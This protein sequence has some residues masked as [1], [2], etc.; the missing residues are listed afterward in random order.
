MANQTL[1]PNAPVATDVNTKLPSGWD[2]TTFQNFKTANPNISWPTNYDTEK[3][4]GATN[5][6]SPVTP[7]ES[8]INSANLTPTTPMNVTQPTPATSMTG[9]GGVT[10]SNVKTFVQ[11]QSDNLKATE[12]PTQSFQDYLDGITSA[13][14]KSGTEANIYASGGVDTANSE[15]KD[16]NNQIIAEQVA[17]RRRLEA[18]DK[19]PNGML[20]SGLQAEKDRINRE[21]ISK[22]ADLAVIQMSKQGKYDSAKAIADRLVDAKMEEQKNKLD[23]LQ[24]T[25]ENN[26]SNFTLAEQRDF[27]ARQKVDERKYEEDKTNLKEIS[28]LSIKALENGA[29]V[30]IASQMR[31]ATKL[32]D[33]IVIGGQYLR[34]Q[35][36]II[37]NLTPGNS[38]LSN[39]FNSAVTGMPAGQMK[40]ATATFNSLVNSGDTA[41]AKDYLARVAVAGAPTDQQ[42][43][44]IGRKQAIDSLNEVQS[45]LEQAKNAGATTNI[46]TGNFNDVVNKLGVSNDPNLTYIG[47]RIA[48]V[49]QTYR[50]SM[51]GV[52]FSPAE[53]A[54]YEKVFPS[55]TN[56][57]KLNATKLAA[58]RDSLNSNNRTALSFYIGTSNYDKIFGESQTGNLPGSEKVSITPED[59]SLFDSIVGTKTEIPTNKEDPL[60]P[61]VV[62]A[63]VFNLSEWIK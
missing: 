47:S 14:T 62:K 6:S 2:A 29:P 48:S 45:L 54:Q 38:D 35:N 51:T 28:D 57:D 39:A 16:I 11:E 59:T 33:A 5:L 42:N 19:N 56:T 43:Q 10:E 9:L 15:L 52:A 58:L 8:A 1:D 40:Q 21:S 25:Y 41:G 49:L 36:S 27:E 20:L 31:S 46:L 7:T 37:N 3:M 32:S 4:M 55:V 44:I 18:L 17:N 23:A 24:L 26:K 53:S 34:D 13:D 61:Y 12:K 22:Q 63:P 60:S 30:S 50:R